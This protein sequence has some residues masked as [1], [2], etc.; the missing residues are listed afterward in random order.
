MTGTPTP[1]LMVQLDPAQ[2]PSVAGPK[3]ALR[4][5]HQQEAK[6]PKTR[7][8]WKR[9]APDLTRE[10]LL[11]LLIVRAAWPIDL[12]SLAALTALPA[13]HVERILYS[14]PDY[15][16]RS[17]YADGVRYVPRPEPSD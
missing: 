8:L 16:Y 12:E 6:Q 14:L 9:A 11:L 17:P 7:P 10:Q 4:A 13:E 15:V 1:R 2:R 3:A 5:L